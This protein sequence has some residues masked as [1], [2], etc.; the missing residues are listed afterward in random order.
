MQIV[1]E[2]HRTFKW[3]YADPDLAGHIREAL[4]LYFGIRWR[5]V[6]GAPGRSISFSSLFSVDFLR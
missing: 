1:A 6:L 4:T 5:G 2:F 3:R